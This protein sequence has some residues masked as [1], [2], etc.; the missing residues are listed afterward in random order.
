MER[1]YVFKI[2]VDV[3]INFYR[4]HHNVDG[5]LQS[6]GRSS[7]NY[8]SANSKYTIIK[9]FSCRGINALLCLLVINTDK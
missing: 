9:I 4:A 1:Y 7:A 2:D 3:T 5:N 8:G 6:M